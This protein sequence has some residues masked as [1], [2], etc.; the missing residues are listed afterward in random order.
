MESNHQAGLLDDSGSWR[1]PHA[2]NP[3]R[4][5]QDSGFVPAYPKP[6]GCVRR[7]TKQNRQ[8]ST[9]FLKCAA[10]VVRYQRFWMELSLLVQE[11]I[12]FVDFA[13]S[14]AL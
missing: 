5:L 13:D 10:T 8:S 2:L 12:I 7:R 1:S 9:Y 14:R 4:P 11:P 3:I 6:D